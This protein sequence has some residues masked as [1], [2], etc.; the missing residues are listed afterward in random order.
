ML[1]PLCGLVPIYPEIARFRVNSHSVDSSSVENTIRT[2]RCRKSGKARILAQGHFDL[3]VDLSLPS[4]QACAWVSTFISGMYRSSALSGK[5]EVGKVVE[6][7]DAE[8]EEVFC[9][10][11]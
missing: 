11:G 6:H 7:G 4:K 3:E 10:T 1:S 5:P 8:L 2:V 9:V